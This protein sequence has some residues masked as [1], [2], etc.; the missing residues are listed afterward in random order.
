MYVF[1]AGIAITS[2]KVALAGWLA[3]GYFNSTTL[4]ILHSQ[5]PKSVTTV[6]HSVY[7]RVSQIS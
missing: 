1:I 6:C 7:E 3:G 4:P 5:L 2:I